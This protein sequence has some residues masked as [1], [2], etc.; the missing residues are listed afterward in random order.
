MQLENHKAYKDI[1]NGDSSSA[2]EVMNR[3][4]EIPN[5]R[6]GRKVCMCVFVN[7]DST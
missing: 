2:V 3:S 7:N 4:H 1:L 6:W 5:L